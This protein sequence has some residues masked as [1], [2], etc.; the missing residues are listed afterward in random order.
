MLH[1][2]FFF[3]SSLSLNWDSP[4]WLGLA[5]SKL[6]GATCLHIP[7]LDS[8]C[9][10]Q[11]LTFYVCAGDP[12]SGSHAYATSPF[13]TEPLPQ[14][15]LHGQGCGFSWARSSRRAWGLALGAALSPQPSNA[16]EMRKQLLSWKIRSL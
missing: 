11:C 3:E 7:A 14:P 1:I 13:P 2:L 10:S 6:W 12:T 4:T 15:P 16:V 9:T 5:V 8:I